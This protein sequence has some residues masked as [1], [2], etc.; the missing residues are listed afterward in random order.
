MVNIYLAPGQAGSYRVTGEAAGLYREYYLGCAAGSYN[1][2]PRERRLRRA[3]GVYAISAA[4]S[5]A[6]KISRIK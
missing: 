5:R 2:T 6:R 3:A 4:T 1:A